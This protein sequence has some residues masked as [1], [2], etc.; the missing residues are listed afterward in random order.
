M[1]GK[2]SGGFE[3]ARRDEAAAIRLLATAAKVVLTS[4]S[5]ATLDRIE[6]TLRAAAA[7][8]QGREF[9]RKGRL[10]ED[11]EP[12]GFEAL[13][14]L[15]VPTPTK[16]PVARSA[17]AKEKQLQAKLEALR[18]R[19]RDADRTAERRDDEATELERAARDADDLARKAT[20]AAVTARKSAD[21]AAAAAERIKAEIA[22]LERGG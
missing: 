14:G 12:P 11:L 20:R 13:S 6:T 2:A 15:A 9:I 4:T 18:Q 22:E 5:T 21:D 1:S 10:A 19:R 16:Q 8:Q 17:G 3:T 7:T